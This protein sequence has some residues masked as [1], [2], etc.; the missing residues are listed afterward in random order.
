MQDTGRTA[1][2]RLLRL[3]P[4]NLKNTTLRREG[5]GR[6]KTR[7]VAISCKEVNSMIAQ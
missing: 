4:N 1:R 5:V 6:C 3:E 2:L 7:V